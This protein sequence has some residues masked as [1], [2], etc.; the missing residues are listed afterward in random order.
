MGD[1]VLS[2][3]LFCHTEEDAP[4]APA[5]IKVVVSSPQS[6]YVSWLPPKEANGQ[7]TKYNLYTRAVNGREE[8]NHEKRNLP[9]QQLFYEAK[10][11]QPMREYQFWVTSSTRIGEGKSSRV[12]S[13][14][15]S[16]RIAARIVS[17]G[18]L[19]IIPWKQTANLQ[20]T[21]V[22]QPKLEWYKK[23]SIL[24][25]GAGNNVQILDTGELI[26][27]NLGQAD[28]GNYSC[29]VDNG[30]STDRITY[31]LLVQVPPAPPMLYVT[32]ATSS[33]I[34]MHWK[35]SVTGNA[36]ITGYT[37]HYRRSHGNM[38]ELQLS[39]HATSQELKELACGSVY[40]IYLTASNKIGT[41]AGSQTLHVR[42]QGQA[43]GIPQPPALIAPN[44]S[45][46]VLRLNSWPD[47]GCPI[48]FFNIQFRLLADGSEWNLVGK[49]LKPQKRYTIGP[50]TPS[51]L[52]QLKVDAVNM[53]GMTTGDFTFVTLTKDG[54]EF[55]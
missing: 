12:V 55:D 30:I 5:D 25:N 35:N 44:S 7:I 49:Q 14:V 34:L 13:Q 3:P 10:N 41:S 8:I 45:T 17:F 28:S 22:G 20:C 21:A 48:L 16:T 54:G 24:K 18:G 39:R 33:S 50:L 42:T 31:N 47:N 36:P 51:T 46:V 11:L 15:T 1:G 43:P 53:A 40:Q 29:Q 19:V 4:E 6:L 27:T 23:D 37:L 32:S 9:S 38:E 2:Q 52:Y 26:I